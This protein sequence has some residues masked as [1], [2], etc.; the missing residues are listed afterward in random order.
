MTFAA[1]AL[2]PHMAE[3]TR[4]GEEISFTGKWTPRK[5]RMILGKSDDSKKM[6]S[7]L[8]SLHTL[9]QSDSSVL[10]FELNDSV[11]GDSLVAHSV[12]V[13]E[14]AMI[15]FYDDK[16]ADNFRSLVSHADADLHLLRG[17]SVSAETI[18]FFVNKSVPV[19][20]GEHL[21]GYVKND[22]QQPNLTAAID[23]TAKWT[24]IEGTG[25]HLEELKHWWQQV[26]TDAFDIEKGLIRFEVYQVPGEEALLI[27]E[28][29]E[30]TAELKFHLTKGTAHKY[31][32]SIDRIAT[33]ERYVFRGNVSWLIRTYSKFMRLPATYS[34][35]TK[36]FTISGGSMSDGTTSE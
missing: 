27:H 9:A 16:G 28:V 12:F 26:G 33:P 29:F 22:S 35:R 32:K 21:F 1:T 24:C 6:R 25:S 19:S 13:D 11:S 23:V 10:S 5:S 34:T 18:D 17:V 31:K 15:D 7:A 8:Q 2:P 36:R 3:P 14:Q 20:A 30:N 4:I